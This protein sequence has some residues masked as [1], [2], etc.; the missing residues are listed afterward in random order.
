MGPVTPVE[1]LLGAAP[2]DDRDGAWDGRPDADELFGV[3]GEGTLGPALGEPEQF[4]AAI[5]AALVSP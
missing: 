4:D 1:P 3:P 2:Q 5:L